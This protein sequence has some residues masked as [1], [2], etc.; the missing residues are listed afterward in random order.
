VAKRVGSE[1]ENHTKGI[2]NDWAKRTA[3]R[4]GGERPVFASI[5]N[6]CANPVLSGSLVPLSGILER[7]NTDD[8]CAETEEKLASSVT[9][10]AFKDSRAA[11]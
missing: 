10:F 5:Y 7:Q 1:G 2:A 11:P 4:F 6:W 8:E 3:P 9:S